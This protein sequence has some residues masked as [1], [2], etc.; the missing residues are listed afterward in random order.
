[1]STDWHLFC[2]TCEEDGWGYG[3][4]LNHRNLALKA[5]IPHMTLFAAVGRAG[6]D[7]DPESF[8][9]YG[10]GTRG[11]AA[12]AAKH[13]GHRI[14][15]KSEYGA[16]DDECSEWIHCPAC[17]HQDMRCTLPE[18]HD[19]PHD[20]HVLVHADGGP[21]HGTAL[22]NGRCPGCGIAPDMQSTELWERGKVKL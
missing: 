14:R 19:G 2:A 22:V 11:L 15:V 21:C 9:F 4:D 1:M 8:D 13:D 17:G 18:G 6:F 3:A 7:I 5:L 10:S 20:T 12:W 16:F